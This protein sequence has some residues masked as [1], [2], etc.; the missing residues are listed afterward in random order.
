MVDRVAFPSS[1]RRAVL[2]DYVLARIDAMSVSIAAAS[3]PLTDTPVLIDARSVC[4]LTLNQSTEI[5]GLSLMELPS[6]KSPMERGRDAGDAGGSWTFAGS[7]SVA[8]IRD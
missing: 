6:L 8:M 4:S 1:R 7:T 5:I 2:P 3:C